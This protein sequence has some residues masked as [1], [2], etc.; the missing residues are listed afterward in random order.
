MS[1]LAGR[2]TLGLVL[3]M[4]LSIVGA[5]VCYVAWVAVVLMWARDAPPVL[6]AVSWVTAPIVT[7]LG[8]AI[9]IWISEGLTGARAT[10]F[11]RLLAWPLAGCAV[12]AAVVCPFGPML[13][14]FGI[15]VGGYASACLRELVLGTRRGRT[16]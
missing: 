16:A 14:V 5:G 13:I 12:G 15:F 3:R 8:W 2:P 7:G 9:G 4:L 6:R 10:G 11:L 1:T